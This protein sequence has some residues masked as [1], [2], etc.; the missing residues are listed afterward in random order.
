M[1]VNNLEVTLLDYDHTGTAIGGLFEPFDTIKEAQAYLVGLRAMNA[2]FDEVRVDV[3]FFYRSEVTLTS[4]V[5]GCML[6]QLDLL[7]EAEINEE[8]SEAKL[9][10]AFTNSKAE[11]PKKENKP[12]EK[13]KTDEKPRA[14]EKPLP[15]WPSYMEQLEIS[16][17]EIKECLLK[18]D[19]VKFTPKYC[20]ARVDA[21]KDS[22]AWMEKELDVQKHEEDLKALLKFEEEERKREQEAAGYW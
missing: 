3:R 22:L 10:K 11:A 9:I 1:K 12:L 20:Q 13:P 14:V 8:S 4:D 6:R 15:E 2:N 19:A 18:E 17:A 5:I 7:A 16:I 21:W